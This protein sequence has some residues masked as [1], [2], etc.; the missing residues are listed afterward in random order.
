MKWMDRKAALEMGDKE[1]SINCWAHS[2]RNVLE[3]I[4]STAVPTCFPQELTLKKKRSIYNIFQLLVEKPLQMFQTLLLLQFTVCT[5]GPRQE[6][7]NKPCSTTDTEWPLSKIKAMIRGRAACTH[8]NILYCSGTED[9]FS[10]AR[11]FAILGF[12]WSH[13]CHIGKT[14]LHFILSFR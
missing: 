10:L 11:E 9:Q 5:L 4:C 2:R 13:S 3:R 1:V 7:L 6:L 12:C 14:G 8:F